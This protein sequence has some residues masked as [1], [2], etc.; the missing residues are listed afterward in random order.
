MLALLAIVVVLGPS[1]ASADVACVA[2]EGPAAVAVLPWVWGLGAPSPSPRVERMPALPSG[3]ATAVPVPAVASG[4]GRR[5][6][7]HTVLGRLL[8]SRG[9]SS[10]ARTHLDQ[11]ARDPDPAVSACGR[12]AVEP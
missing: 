10:D 3:E 12:S 4:E 6:A 2:V 9:E 11:A 5:G 7:V 1:A 8:S